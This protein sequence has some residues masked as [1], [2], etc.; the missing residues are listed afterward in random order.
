MQPDTAMK[1]VRKLLMAGG[2][3]S[4]KLAKELQVPPQLIDQLYH[5]GQ[6]P[7]AIELRLVRLY[8]K[9]AFSESLVEY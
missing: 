3:S 1:M 4:T 9:T 6:I 2:Y 5:G 8:C 7:A